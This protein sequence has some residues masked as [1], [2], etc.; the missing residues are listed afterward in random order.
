MFPTSDH[1]QMKFFKMK[2]L[3]DVYE[4]ELY[5]HQIVFNQKVDF[6]NLTKSQKKKIK[7]IES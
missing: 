5:G 2:T 4:Y 6:K 3:Q 7:K 1:L